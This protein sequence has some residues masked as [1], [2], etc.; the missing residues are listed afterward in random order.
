M[1]TFAVLSIAA[2]LGPR[3]GVYTVF[4]YLLA[5][6]GGLPA[7]AQCGPGARILL[8]PTGGYLLGF[9]PAVY[10]TGRLLQSSRK[11]G[12]WV[13]FLAGLVGAMTILL[14]GA[15]RLVAFVDLSQAYTLGMAPF[16]LGD[17]LKVVTFALLVRGK[18]TVL[19]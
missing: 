13:P 5:G 7:F 12:F 10:F 17:F 6:V 19:S 15:G 11:E 8:S 9:I 2:K 4:L 1:Q 3:F 18:R 16:L 14:C